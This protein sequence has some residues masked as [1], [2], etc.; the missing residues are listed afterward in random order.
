MAVAEQLVF[1]P[2]QRAAL[3]GEV[4][5]AGEAHRL[6]ARGPVERLGDGGPPVDDDRLALLV[7]DRQ[8]ADVEGLQAIGGLGHAVDST[9]HQ[10]G[11][12]EIELGQPVDH[13]L[14]EHIALVAGLERAPEGALVEVAHPPGRVAADF[15]APIGVLDEVLFGGKIGVLLRHGSFNSIGRFSTVPPARPPARPPADNRWSARGSRSDT[16]ADSQG[17]SRHSAVPYR[18]HWVGVGELQGAGEM[19]AIGPLAA[20]DRG[21]DPQQPRRQRRSVPPVGR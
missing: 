3:H 9:E 20:N 21:T 19:D 8:S 4:P 16:Q 5:A 18:N 7:G 14:V 2:E 1:Q 13:G 10:G 15:E 6:A 11:V 12:A 17:T